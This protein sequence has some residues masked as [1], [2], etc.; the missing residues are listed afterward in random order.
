M[1]P[2]QTGDTSNLPNKNVPLAK[3]SRELN[4][5][6]CRAV[7]LDLAGFGERHGATKPTRRPGDLACNYSSRLTARRRFFYRDE[8]DAA[9]ATVLPKLGTATRI[10]LTVDKNATFDSFHCPFRPRRGTTPLQGWGGGVARGEEGEHF[11]GG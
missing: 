8:L 10:P 6:S 2:A 5:L 11:S 9:L 3:D 1:A 7:K 4:K